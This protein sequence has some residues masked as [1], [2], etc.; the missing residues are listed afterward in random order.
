MALTASVAD[1]W[2]RGGLSLVAS[3]KGTFHEKAFGL[4]D[5]SCHVCCVLAADCRNRTSA[6]WNKLQGDRQ[7][8]CKSVG[9][10]HEA[11]V[12]A[13][14]ARSDPGDVISHGLPAVWSAGPDRRNG[15]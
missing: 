12:R 11:R 6:N 8:S 9:F 13:L 3:G 4:V 10:Y 2:Q 1:W 7:R 15:Q 14:V 5:I